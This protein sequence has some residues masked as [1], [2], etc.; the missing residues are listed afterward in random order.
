MARTI[1]Y[2]ANPQWGIISVIAGD[3]IIS[4][5][6]KNVINITSPTSASS[7]PKFC[8]II[9]ESHEFN[10]PFARPTT[11]NLAWL[12]YFAPKSG[13]REIALDVY[14]DGV[15]LATIPFLLT[16]ERGEIEVPRKKFANLDGKE[17]FLTDKAI[18]SH[19]QKTKHWNDVELLYKDGDIEIQSGEVA[20]LIAV[21]GCE[22]IELEV[23]S[24]KPYIYTAPITK[25]MVRLY[26]VRSRSV[27]GSGRSVYLDKYI[28]QDATCADI[29]L[30]ITN[31]YGLRGA[32]GGKLVDASEGGSDV[33]ANYS[34]STIPYAGVFSWS[35]EG[36]VVKKE[37]A[38]NFN[39]DADLLA[40]LRDACVYGNVEWFDENSQKWLPCKIEDKSVDNDPWK[41]QIITIVLQQL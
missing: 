37:V 20:S 40:L 4:A 9:F 16:A 23:G 28:V 5:Y 13:V 6:E 17:Y 36:A 33:Q 29:E 34:S 7:T 15:K 26:A 10:L 22:Y 19:T 35:K 21:S 2:T 41:E 8:K 12:K 25:E 24:D 32:I 38:F 14:A 30:L 31:R 3:T 11:F 39:G 27:G 1:N 18:L